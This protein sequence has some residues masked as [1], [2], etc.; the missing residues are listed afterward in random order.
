MNYSKDEIER[1]N[2]EWARVNKLTA[3][4]VRNYARWKAEEAA[5]QR[6]EQE[7][8]RA[9]RAE[10]AK[11]YERYTQMSATAQARRDARTANDRQRERRSRIDWS[12]LIDDPMIVERQ[13]KWERRQTALAMHKAGLTSVEIGKRL[14]ISRGRAHQLF[15]KA[16]RDG[17]KLSPAEQYINKSLPAA[18][19]MLQNVHSP[20]KMKQTL[21]TLLPPWLPQPDE[22]TWI[23]MGIAA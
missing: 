13:E 15:Y 11:R 14:G 18:V 12:E 8:L 21:V 23:W 6:K 3:A 19:T 9:R 16:E 1:L 10:E 4:R 17:E 7:E 5:T 20:R 2:A 22:D